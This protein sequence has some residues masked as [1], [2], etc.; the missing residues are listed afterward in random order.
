MAQRSASSRFD[1]PQPFGPTTPVNP[2]S[3]RISVGSTK[4]L[5]PSRRRRVIFKCVWF[6]GHERS[7]T[8]FKASMACVQVEDCGPIRALNSSKVMEPCALRP[9]AKKVGVPTTPNFRPR[10][11]TFVSPSIMV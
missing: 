9:L 8:R 11:F 2:G 5:K 7:D 1:L 10:C 6:L 4:D 3:T